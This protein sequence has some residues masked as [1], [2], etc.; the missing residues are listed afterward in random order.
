[1]PQWHVLDREEVSKRHL[2]VLIRLNK[3]D[4]ERHHQHLDAFAC[5]HQKKPRS[6]KVL[7]GRVQEASFL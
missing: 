2:N 4:S 5:L 6:S 1:M 7:E 3:Q